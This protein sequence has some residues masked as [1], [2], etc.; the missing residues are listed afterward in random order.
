MKKLVLSAAVLV[1]AM[2]LGVNGVF[3]EQTDSKTTDGNVGFTT[4][5]DGLKL[6][7]AANLDFGNHE[8]SASDQ[9]YKSETDTKSTV[10]DIRGTLTGWTLQ[11]AQSEQFKNGTNELTNAQI[12]LD[13][14]VL[15]ESS[16][17]TANVKTAVALKPTGESVVIMDANEGEGNGVATEDFNTGK[18]SLSVPG[19]TVKVA[20]KYQTTLVW[21]L[22]DSVENN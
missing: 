22:M 10:Q 6:I 15:D 11:V 5:A 18:A 7:E 19:S 8:I 16:T 12:T 14:P 20:G 21:S 4:P 3:A 13:E 9:T 2:T 1:G 17:A